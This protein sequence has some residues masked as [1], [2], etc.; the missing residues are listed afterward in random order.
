MLNSG[1]PPSFS[2]AKFDW[3]FSKES[4]GATPDSMSC[5][6]KSLS[7]QVAVYVSHGHL[8]TARQWSANFTRDCVSKVLDT[9]VC[10]KGTSY[11]AILNLDA[12]IREYPALGQVSDFSENMSESQSIGAATRNTFTVLIKE[13][14]EYKCPIFQKQVY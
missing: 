3:I 14:C 5:T 2:F 10:S 11:S 4:D 8:N 12:K 7:V 9:V 6:P 1:R 13:L